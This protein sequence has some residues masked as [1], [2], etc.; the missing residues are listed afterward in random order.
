MAI[1]KETLP[2]TY[3]ENYQKIAQ[4]FIDKG[5][6]APYEGSNTAVITSILSYVVSSLNLNTAANINENILTLANKRDNAIA[7]ARILS[8]E[9]HKKKSSQLKISLQFFLTGI[10]KLSKYAQFEINGFNYTYFGEDQLLNI[11]KQNEIVEIIVK[12]GKL[13]K[14]EEY[15]G[16]LTYKIDE[17]FEYIDIPWDDIEDDGIEVF[18]KYYDNFGVQVNTT[19]YVKKQ[20]NVIEYNDSNEKCFMRKDDI[21][22]GNARIYFK[23]SSFGKK[24]PSNAIVCVNVLRTSGIKAFYENCASAK[25]KDSILGSCCK[26]IKNGNF[27]PKVIVSASD[28]ESI[29]K[30]KENAPQLYNTSAR[31]V[32]TYDYESIIKKHSNIKDA[33]VWGGEDELPISLGNIY[34]TPLNNNANIISK[35]NKVVL[36]ENKFYYS[37]EVES[38]NS[39][40]Q[41]FIN[42]QYDS[43]LNYLQEGDIITSNEKQGNGIFNL[44]NKY[45]LPAL[46]N[47]LLHP[48]FIN[49]DF[50]IKIKSYPLG[51]TKADIR[52]A[53]FKK[54]QE[55]IDEI[56]AFNKIFTY[57]N[58]MRYLDESLGI[59]NGIE[60]TPY[61]SIL[62]NK[63]N[64]IKKTA[65][66]FKFNKL[67]C[68]YNT[69]YDK[70]SNTLLVQ[71]FLPQN[72]KQNDTIVFYLNSS[73]IADVSNDENI[74]RYSVSQDDVESSFIN[75]YLRNLGLRND[76]VK[77]TYIN[78]NGVN[79][80]GG[81]DLNLYDFKNK[82]IYYNVKANNEVNNIKICLPRFVNFNDTIEVYGIYNNAA[83]ELIKV[84]H[85]ENKDLFD[86]F[87]QFDDILRSH[88]YSNLTHPIT[89]KVV[90][91]NNRVSNKNNLS[92][93][94]I[95]GT[96]CSSFEN[97]WENT[98]TQDSVF[99]NT[100]P[101]ELYFN[102]KIKNSIL[103]IKIWIPENAG[104]QDQIV[105]ECNDITEKIILTQKIIEEGVIDKIFEL[106]ELSIVSAEYNGTDKSINIF[107]TQLQKKHSLIDIEDD[108]INFNQTK[109]NNIIEF[110]RF[111]TWDNKIQLKMNSKIIFYIN[112]TNKFDVR[113]LIINYNEN[114]VISISVPEGS[115]LTIEDNFIC[116]DNPLNSE[117]LS[118]SVNVQILNSE[119]IY[120]TFNI[121]VKVAPLDI[122]QE[123][124]RGGA[125]IYLDLPKEGI[126][127]DK[128]KLD[129][130]KLP[131]IEYNN[132][133]FSIEDTSNI[134]SWQN[135]LDV[136]DDEDEEIDENSLP[137]FNF[138]EKKSFI[139]KISYPLT[140]YE[141]WDKNLLNIERIAIDFT[142]NEETVGNILPF[143][144]N[145]ETF[146]EIDLRTISYLKFPIYWYNVNFKS[147]I[148]IGIYQIFNSKSP[149]IK[150][151][152]KKEV[153][154]EAKEFSLSYPSN[155][156]N[157][158]KNS[159]FKLRSVV[160]DEEVDY[161]NI[162]EQIRSGKTNVKLLEQ[163]KVTQ[164]QAPQVSQTSQNTSTPRE[165]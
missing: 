59:N 56:S 4:K 34:V 18:V 118:F 86:G 138:E 131:K 11:T 17:N 65:E 26:I 99:N 6:D 58:I 73:N 10:F 28:E 72:A 44:I 80:I 122:I 9:P 30:I 164:S 93:A 123:E 22:T 128:G 51:S 111:S 150:I 137:L 83:E 161:Y 110:T 94:Q 87:V 119:I 115:P 132:F 14:Y 38:E 16:I 102:Y 25:I 90:Y 116:Y 84:F 21:E 139:N 130:T 75:L 105:I 159:I 67:N 81:I 91:T 101:Y 106:P 37:K 149:Y 151:K 74:F 53:I 43:D 126:Y 165:S 36:A 135:E 63:N 147:R 108:S 35:F 78:K 19:Q 113:N 49:I 114:C 85:I 52:N 27:S 5:W 31:I 57:S 50:S 154:N 68:F 98:K 8:Y 145:Y 157:L 45:N 61:F 146:K 46:Q 23:L 71:V 2:F 92:E 29:E 96:I 82:K 77:V 107:H 162:R 136:G 39:F 69:N 64:L 66:D 129:V 62:L 155:N 33:V 60:I 32:T 163:K 121:F 95:Q 127:S 133:G 144:I 55:K 104:V 158:I 152:F 142:I 20:L 156:I 112:Y 117:V 70:L 143:Y 48:V 97:A 41:Y 100:P 89:Y 40:N 1:I 24:L 12:E 148:L 15:P 54:L 103:D 76:A 125:Y 140:S 134:L 120:G 13:Y 109:L 153:V 141:N 47:N 88:A 160:F 3:D 124:G 7:A 42:E 79:K